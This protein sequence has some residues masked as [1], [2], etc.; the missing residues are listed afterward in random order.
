MKL[1]SLDVNYDFQQLGSIFLSEIWGVIC[2]KYKQH[3]FV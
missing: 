1:Q 3:Y 2:T